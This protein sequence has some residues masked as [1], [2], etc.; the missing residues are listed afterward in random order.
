[1]FLNQH[2]IRMQNFG[3]CCPA[4]LPIR[5]VGRSDDPRGGGHVIMNN[6]VDLMVEIGINDQPKSRGRAHAPLAPVYP[7]TLVFSGA[8]ASRHY[9]TYLTTRDV[10]RL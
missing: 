2:K 6:V 1:M 10:T 3:G 8:S 4:T 9:A 5:A 7:A